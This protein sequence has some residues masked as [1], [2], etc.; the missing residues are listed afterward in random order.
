MASDVGMGASGQD[1]KQRNI[2]IA[3]VVVVVLLCCCCISAGVA[4]YLWE[5]GDQLM[6]GLSSLPALHALI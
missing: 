4:Y 1:N 6:E 3:V 2:I 5:N